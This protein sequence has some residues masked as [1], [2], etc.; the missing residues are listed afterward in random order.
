M[1]IT[2]RIVDNGRGALLVAEGSVSGQELLEA[3]ARLFSSQEELAGIRYRM[4]DYS[5][6]EEAQVTS[7]DIIAL[8]DL[9]KKMAQRTPGCVVALVADKNITY[10]LGRMWQSRLDA[11][12]VDWEVQV[13]RA[14]PEAEEW[15]RARMRERHG[16]EPTLA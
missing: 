7:A 4:S 14:R 3:H 5:G 15:I 6:V 11:R 12:D 1:A 8:A 9:H 10:G 16:F 13:F 2:T